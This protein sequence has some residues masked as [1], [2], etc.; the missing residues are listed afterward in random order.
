MAASVS[1]VERSER[2]GFGSGRDVDLAEND[3][4][5]NGV[6]RMDHLDLEEPTR[7][8]NLRFSRML[9]PRSKCSGELRRLKAACRLPFPPFSE[10]PSQAASRRNRCPAT[11]ARTGR[12]WF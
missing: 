9:R 10:A 2:A 5:F 1:E 4:N 3:C 6:L 8:E 12:S 11:D 7:H